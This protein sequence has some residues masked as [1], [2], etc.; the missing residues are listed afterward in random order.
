MAEFE[1]RELAP[2][3]V[4]IQPTGLL[5]M[6]A[7]PAL[8]ERL[9]ELVEAGNS[10][11]VVDLVDV[12]SVDSSGLGALI[13][14]LKSARLAGG[15]LRIARPGPQVLTVLEFTSLN[16]VLQAYDSVESAFDEQ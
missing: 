5:N 11:I 1:T 16:R 10:R 3:T 13:S 8:R 6:V 7:A 14:G 12:E 4:A 9:R 15:D 2:G